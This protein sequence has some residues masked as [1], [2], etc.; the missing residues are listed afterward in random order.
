MT[1]HRADAPTWAFLNAQIIQEAEATGALKLAIANVEQRHGLPSGSLSL[2]NSA[3][4]L[5][6]LYCMLVIPKEIW[7][8]DALPP[9]LASLDPHPILA[10]FSVTLKPSKFDEE[11]FHTLLRRL[12]NSVAH[13]RFAI[14]DSGK[15]TFWDQRNDST[16]KDFEASITSDSLSLF[17]STV[18]VALSNF[19]HPKRVN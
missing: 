6:L 11:P 10:L 13:A 2:R 15:I 4:V 19:R 8:R 17:L 7:A 3:F 1:D 14:D 5:S 12:R 16:P 18:G 9:E